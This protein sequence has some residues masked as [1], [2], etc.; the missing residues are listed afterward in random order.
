MRLNNCDRT[1]LEKVAQQWNPQ[2]ARDEEKVKMQ[3][4]IYSGISVGIHS[5]N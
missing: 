4:H 3:N 1:S 2:L 5:N